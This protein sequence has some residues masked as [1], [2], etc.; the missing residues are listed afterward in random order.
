MTLTSQSDC[1]WRDIEILP[2]G[3]WK[4][5]LEMTGRAWLARP[6]NDLVANPE[7]DR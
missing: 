6:Q 2:K 4:D 3:F 5:L 7:Y 1:K